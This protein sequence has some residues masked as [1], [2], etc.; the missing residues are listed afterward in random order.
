MVAAST[1]P[2]DLHKDDIAARRARFI[3]TKEQRKKNQQ[4]DE[5]LLR[6]I[7][8]MCI[9]ENCRRN[10]RRLLWELMHKLC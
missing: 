1:H 5:T 8:I 2:L 9:T 3:R 4:L 7:M 10:E 6:I